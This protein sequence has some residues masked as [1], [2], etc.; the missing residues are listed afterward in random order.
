VRVQKIS[1]PLGFISQTVHSV[2]SRTIPTTLSRPLLVKLQLVRCTMGTAVAQWLKYC[3][4]DRNVA[5]AM[6]A[7]VTGIFH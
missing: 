2:E 4:A 1:R 5:G 6:A 3:A 7:G